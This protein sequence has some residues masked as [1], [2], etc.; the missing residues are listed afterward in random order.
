[1]INNV[2]KSLPDGILIVEDSMPIFNTY[3]VHRADKFHSKDYPEIE[4]E[5][6]AITQAIRFMPGYGKVNA[7]VSFLK[8]QSVKSEWVKA[9]P[10][11]MKMI[12]SGT[13]KVSHIECMFES[14]RDNPVFLKDFEKYIHTVLDEKFG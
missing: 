9:N 7:T 10:V 13:F 12:R 6:T 11:L 3:H 4:I 1:M 5:L 2:R 14:C 8:N